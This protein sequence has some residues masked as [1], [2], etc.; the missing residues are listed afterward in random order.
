MLDF[1]M[2]NNNHVIILIGAI[3]DKNLY[4]EILEIVKNAKL[5][6]KFYIHDV[7][8]HSDFQNALK[9][10]QLV[11]NTS[12]SEG[13]S[14]VIMESMLNGVPV[15]ARSN[16]GNLKLIKHHYNGLIFTD[17]EDFSNNLN[18]FY[19][20]NESA[21]RNQIIENARKTISEYFGYNTE[22]KKYEM[23]FDNVFKNNYIPFEKGNVKLQLYFPT[24]IHPFSKENNEIFEVS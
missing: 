3:L 13:M 10:V 8:D 19:S 4:K 20:S 18:K 9:E 11:I 2:K 7:I 23:L 5:D 21:L 12:I 6:D 22:K 24:Y 17:K 1:L 16:E 14:N 15:L